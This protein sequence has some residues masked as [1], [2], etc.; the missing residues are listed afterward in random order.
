MKQYLQC[1]L[2]N[3]KVVDVYFRYND[4]Y[5]ILVDTSILVIK[6]LIKK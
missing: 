2:F 4:V 6:H 1:I 3:S 5:Y